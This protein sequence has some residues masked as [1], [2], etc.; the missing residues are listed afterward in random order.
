MAAASRRPARLLHTYL[1]RA[2][3]AFADHVAL[4]VPPG[5]GR[6]D[7]LRWTYA[8]LDR[9][10]DALAAYLRPRVRGEA[11]VAI[12]LP[13]TTPWLFAAEI[14]ALRVGAAFTA[15]DPA[16][17]P[18]QVA[19]YLGYSFFAIFLGNLYSG[20]WAGWLYRHFVQSPAQAGQAP[21]PLWFFAGV[22]VMGAVATVGLGLYG[23][24]VSISDKR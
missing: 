5:E 1:D 17:P 18:D 3:A 8:E 12:R 20:P 13:R 7:R 2:V 16:A 21:A 22:M 23:R 6:P 11:V 14:A 10:A 19:V 15:I 24:F 4:E 9:R